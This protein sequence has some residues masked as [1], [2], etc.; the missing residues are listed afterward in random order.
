MDMDM[1][2]LSYLWT[3]SLTILIDNENEIIDYCLDNMFDT[4][5]RKTDISYHRMGLN[6]VAPKL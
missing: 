3:K 1:N 4:F 2:R 5:I 6:Q